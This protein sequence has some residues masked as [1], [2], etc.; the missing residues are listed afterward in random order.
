MDVELEN[1]ATLED[2]MV[3]ARTYEQRL[4]MADDVSAP[5]LPAK[6]S[7]F[8]TPSKPLLLPAPPSTS[9][10]PLLAPCMKRLSAAEMAAKREKGECFNCTESFSKEHLKT[11]PMKG[12]FL[13]QMDDSMTS[14]T[15]G[16]ADPLIFLNT[17]TNLSSTETMQL[18]VQVREATLAA[19]VDS[20]STHSFILATAAR[21]LDLQSALR[22]SLIVR[23][24][25]G[26]RV[27]SDGVYH[28]TRVLIGSEEF[29]LDLFVIPLDDFEMVLGVQWLR[30]LGLILWDFDRC[31]MSC[32][33][34]NHRVV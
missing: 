12:V 10:A 28:A 21:R 32:W 24:A 1:P 3:L 25:N 17:I 19:L 4:S 14:D 29:T 27:A 16:D 22:P 20:G 15:E 7:A 13:L 31:R 6:E 30:S 18:H 5:A 11:C 23:V 34:D 2:A 33:H 26:D 8:R 9:A